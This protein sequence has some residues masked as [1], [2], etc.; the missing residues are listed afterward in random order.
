MFESCRAHHSQTKRLR[1]AKGSVFGTPFA[2]D[3]REVD[4]HDHKHPWV[5]EM[6]GPG[7]EVFDAERFTAAVAWRS[8]HA[9]TPIRSGL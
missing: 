1:P 3:V 4:L 2:V 6:L 9:T 7:A 5:S 8:E